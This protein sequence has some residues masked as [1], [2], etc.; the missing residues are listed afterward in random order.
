LNELGS[1]NSSSAIAYFI[2]LVVASSYPF[3][4]AFLWPPKPDPEGAGG[5]GGGR[6]GGDP[7][8]PAEEARVRLT[9][10][11]E[12]AHEACRLIESLWHLEEG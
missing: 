11:G 2:M 12:G 6:G 10:R 4:K 3:L 8:A 5:E 9:E 7:Q 1:F